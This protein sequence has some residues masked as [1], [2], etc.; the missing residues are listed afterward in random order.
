[1]T[2]AG[3]SM[4]RI[5]RAPTSYSQASVGYTVGLVCASLVCLSEW[6]RTGQRSS[7]VSK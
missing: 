5:G 3:A 2:R 4:V 6:L 1:M 7:V